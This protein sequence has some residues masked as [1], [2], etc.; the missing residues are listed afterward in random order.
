MV[1]DE[2]G[3]RAAILRQKVD[4]KDGKKKWA[5]LSRSK[6]HKVLKW[7]GAQ[8]PSDEAVQKEEKRIQFFKHQGSVVDAL[9][10]TVEF[11]R[12]TEPLDDPKT[13]VGVLFVCQGRILLVRR[14]EG[15]DD[16]AYWS[17]PGG[18]A[19]TG[20]KGMPTDLW[21]N[22]KRE[23]KEEL[24]SLP[25]GI[26]KATRKHTRTEKKTDKQFVTFVVELPPSG[27]KWKPQLSA[28][29]DAYMWVN[30]LQAKKLPIHPGVR[31][32]LDN[33]SVWAGKFVIPLQIALQRQAQQSL[34]DFMQDHNQRVRKVNRLASKVFHKMAKDLRFVRLEL[35]EVIHGP[36]GA[37]P[38]AGVTGVMRYGNNPELYFD[39]SVSP[40]E[41]GRVR[42]FIRTRKTGFRAGA[43]V[44]LARL[45]DIPGWVLNKLE[46]AVQQEV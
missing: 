41:A 39:V 28:E 44:P 37:T 31:S 32:V 40:R 30:K 23:C 15:E 14:A 45:G 2:L 33:E 36:S 18:H 10:Q 11:D 24:G 35:T 5:L 38:V 9:R 21:G 16:E 25:P 29:H 19:K 46:D 27:M 12:P 42:V 13:V 26:G 1:L 6:P 43:T 7:F 17:V 8:K 3:Y 20:V 22:A 4:D 34:V